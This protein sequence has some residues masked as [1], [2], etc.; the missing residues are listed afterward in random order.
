MISG[1]LHAKS[2]YWYIIL[3]LKDEE[4]KRKPKWISTH[5]KEKGNKKRAEEL[6]QDYRLKY[7]TTE[8]IKKIKHSFIF[9]RRRLIRRRFH[10]VQTVH[11]KLIT[12]W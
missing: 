5:L 12:R 11:H 4:G 10:I 6:L 3:N 2:G 1:H 8:A 9:K 7:S